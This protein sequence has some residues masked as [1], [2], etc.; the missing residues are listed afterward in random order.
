MAQH[1]VYEIAEKQHRDRIA[2]NSRIFD[3]ELT[4]EELAQLDALDEPAAPETLLNAHGGE[5]PGP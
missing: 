4:G 1:Y 5:P 3:F 2:E